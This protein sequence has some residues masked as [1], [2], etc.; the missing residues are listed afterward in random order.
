[1]SAIRTIKIGRI[2]TDT[3]SL[4]GSSGTMELDNHADTTV[5]GRECL[6]FIDYEQPVDVVGYNPSLGSQQC[7]TISGAVAYDHPVTGQVYI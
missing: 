6:P 1:M 3:S 7:P 4:I 5:L 2:E